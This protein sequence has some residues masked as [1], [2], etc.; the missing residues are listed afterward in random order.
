M[1]EFIRSPINIGDCQ[2]FTIPKKEMKL[3]FSKRYRIK[4]EE[5]LE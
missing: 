5:V 3:D 2:G 1:M 4:I